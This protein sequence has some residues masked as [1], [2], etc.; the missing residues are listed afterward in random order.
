MKKLT[1]GLIFTLGLSG[2]STFIPFEPMTQQHKTTSH[3]W[4]YMDTYEKFDFQNKPVSL[5]LTIDTS[6]SE[7]FDLEAA[8][9]KIEKRLIHEGFKVSEDGVELK[10]HIKNAGLLG[11]AYYISNGSSAITSPLVGNGI[12][13]L[14]EAILV[15]GASTVMAKDVKN[16]A[17]GFVMTLNIPSERYTNEIRVLDKYPAAKNSSGNLARVYEKI[18]QIV[19]EII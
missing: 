19:Y 15:T 17:Y 3:D 6:L 9:D 1:L 18:A 4:V 12:M 5:S 14:G 8:R 2:C 13:K 11:E 10:I 7:P 16:P